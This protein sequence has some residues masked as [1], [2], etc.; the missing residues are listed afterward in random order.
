MRTGA[1]VLL[2]GL[3]MLGVLQYRWLREVA[4]AQ[5][6]RM[7][8]DAAS[9]AATIAHAFD[10]EITFA[11]LM[12]RL[13][14]STATASRDAAA[15]AARYDEY[16]RAARWPALVRGVFLYTPGQ[17]ALRRFSPEDRQLLP[18][19]WPKELQPIRERLAA[20]PEAGPVP[21]VVPEVPA[22]LAPVTPGLLGAEPAGP[23][24]HMTIRKVIAEPV[25]PCT[26][27]ELDRNV[28]IGRVLP[29][30]TAE[31]LSAA[32]ASELEASV[33]DATNG[34]VLFGPA[35]SGE[36][37]AGAD[38]LRLRLEELD[39]TLL[40]SL[41][42][43]LAPA[44]NAPRGS[45][46]LVETVAGKDAAVPPAGGWRL[47]LRHKRGSV[48]RAVEAALWRNLAVAFSVLAVLGASVVLIAASA[49]RARALAQR[50]MDFVAAVSHELRTPLA[51]IRSAG[52]NLADGVVSDPPQVKRYGGLVRDEGLRLTEMVEQVLSFAGADA[53]SVHRQPVDLGAVVE[54]ALKT[55]SD[56]AL[57]ERD[58]APDAPRAMGDAA[59]LERAVG[60]LVGN[61]RKYAGEGAAVGVRIESR[62]A[63][64]PPEIAVV[65]WDRG[66]GILPEDRERLFEPFFRGRNARDAQAAGSGLGLAVV[67]RI[68]E[69][70]GGRVEVQSV[71]GEGASFALI[72]EAAPASFAGSD[73]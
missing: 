25:G 29:Q 36:G 31:S 14:M 27:L 51:V 57:V 8:G 12:L 22:L 67:R 38:L 4:D 26:I 49:H 72:L 70:L 7:R 69:S 55:A 59:A 5:R 13:D 73:V 60:N 20:G 41:A 19:E 50:Q 24:Q 17:S 66:P 61:A 54:R 43:N 46:R 53:R 40:R 63:A 1:G 23:G 42:P 39:A 47:I 10:R 44:Q 15:Y 2:L 32:G 68:A 30:I 56:G 64:T 18:A 9:R 71:P 21:A 58:F 11:F 6:S 35:G 62:P 65:V 16:R 48:D 52:D 45:F 28:L 37:D 33:V 3:A 34:A